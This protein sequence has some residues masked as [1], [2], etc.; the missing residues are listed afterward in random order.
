MNYAILFGGR[1]P[2]IIQSGNTTVMTPIIRDLSICGANDCQDP[3]ITDANLSRYE[4]ASP[5]LI[6]ILIGVCAGMVLIAMVIQG[7]LV[8]P[9][10][11]GKEPKYSNGNQGD[12]DKNKSEHIK[13]E[14]VIMCNAIHILK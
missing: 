11:I 8:K 2:I 1:S 9:A 5:I 7:F 3:N 4:P 6:Y 14:E 10:V 12:E 13:A